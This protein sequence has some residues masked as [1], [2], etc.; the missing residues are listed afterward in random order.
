MK[1]I[2]RPIIYLWILLLPLFIFNLEFPE[3]SSEIISLSA[4]QAAE[5]ELD[6][7][8]TEKLIEE[9]I[10][11]R[12]YNDIR[13]LEILEYNL[14]V[15]R[16]EEA[17]REHLAL[18][19]IKLEMGLEEAF[20]FITVDN[21]LEFTVR[22]ARTFLDYEAYM[23]EELTREISSPALVTLLEKPVSL[24]VTEEVLDLS[25]DSVLRG[26]VRREELLE[27]MLLPKKRDEQNRVLTELNVNSG[28]TSAVETTFWSD[29]EKAQLLGFVSWDREAYARDFLY[30]SRSEK[31][32]TF[33]LYLTHRFVGVGEEIGKNMLQLDN[34]SGMIW[35]EKDEVAAQRGYFQLLSAPDIELL[36]VDRKQRAAV[37]M[38][39]EKG[40][41]IIRAGL[42]TVVYD[43]LRLGLVGIF[44]RGDTEKG[45]EV[46]AAV[47]ERLYFDPYLELA[48]GYYP[49]IY[50]LQKGK[51]TGYHAYRAEIALKYKPLSA[52][53]KYRSGLGAPELKAFLGLEVTEGASLLLGAEGSEE[54][55]DKYLL[56]LRLD[57]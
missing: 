5:S 52:R 15:V 12:E 49:G 57:F 36:V 56:G 33:A 43:S 31:S 21:I 46:A 47:N 8:K 38:A 4:V 18:N 34:L 22:G 6:N 19:K 32:T 51:F 42:E 55:V 20:S 29:S 9:G 39:T 28:V 50:N 41:K 13:D 24:R 10:T 2:F 40:F 3:I 30:R 48:G 14:K 44:N 35:P 23:G 37:E 1:P 7:K 27:I 11:E 25:E 26:Q 45:F 16:I 17:E 54:G 53:I